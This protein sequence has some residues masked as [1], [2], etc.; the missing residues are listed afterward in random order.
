VRILEFYLDTANV[1]EV[2]F[3]AKYG[4][5]DGITTNPSIIS[6]ENDTFENVIRRI[7]S[8]IRGKVWI[9]VTEKTADSMY[10]QGLE[11]NKWAKQAVVKLPM[12]E[13]GLEAAYRLSEDNIK[14]NMTLIYTLAQVL[15]AAKVNVDY[16][17]PY[18]GR[19]DDNAVNGQEFISNAKNIIS[20]LGAKTK[21]IGASIRST[22]V[23][24]DL[25]IHQ[26]DAVT[27]PFHIFRKMFQSSLTDE[28]LIQFNHDWECFS[29]K[30][31][32]DS[33]QNFE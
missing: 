29:S 21:I 1:D 31:L 10:Q 2:A 16:I 23:V 14:V 5:L 6:K 7:D 17:S 33:S 22:Q 4:F 24:V 12:N 27:M 13:E 26:Y 30:E 28:G 25:S 19:M 15:L 9:Q 8:Q 20:A 11:I 3:A 32:L 18:I